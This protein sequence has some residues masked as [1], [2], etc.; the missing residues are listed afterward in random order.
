VKRSLSLDVAVGEQVSIGDV[1]VTVEEKSGKRARLRFEANDDVK[2]RKVDNRDTL[3][4][5]MR[6]EGVVG[7]Q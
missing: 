6:E 7:K 1:I 4:R 3:Y 2:I 5:V